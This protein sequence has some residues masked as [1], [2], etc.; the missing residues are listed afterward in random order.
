MSIAAATAVLDVIE[1]EGLLSSADAVGRA[2]LAA[3]VELERRREVLRAARGAGLFIG[4]DIASPKG[5][6]AVLADR[7][8]EGLRERR[9]LL[10][11]TGRDKDVL[12]IRPPLVFSLADADRLVADIVAHG[13]R[14]RHIPSNDDIIDTIVRE[15]RD[16]DVV[17]LMSNGGF[18]G[19]HRKLL[20]ALH[21]RGRD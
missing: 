18:G 20:D 19:I 7:V 11:A 12:K 2:L 9:V 10:A 5:D 17:V 16:G 13:G 6:S 8:V 4:V 1:D 14:A 15:H 3:L 21:G